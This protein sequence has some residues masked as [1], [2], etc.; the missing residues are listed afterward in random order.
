MNYADVT[1]KIIGCAMRV[2]TELG[3]GFR[4]IFTI[5]HLK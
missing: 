2:D 5:R 4:D 1:E 3:F